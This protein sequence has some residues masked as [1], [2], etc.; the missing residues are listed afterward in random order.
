MGIG[1]D[2]GL[3]DVGLVS[4]SLVDVEHWSSP[5]LGGG[6]TGMT[7]TLKT[8][9]RS[10]THYGILE[11]VSVLG[12]GYSHGSSSL[13]GGKSMYVASI[14]YCGSAEVVTPMWSDETCAGDHPHTEATG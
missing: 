10:L 4:V 1:V 5:D 2:V 13:A 3:V 7:C 11:L 8:L 9:A 14:G 6:A 12:V